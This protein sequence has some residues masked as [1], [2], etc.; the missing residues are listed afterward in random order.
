M[1]RLLLIL[2]FCI[3]NLFCYSQDFLYDSN[4]VYGTGVSDDEQTAEETAMLSLS[5]AL[6]TKVIN[7]T[8]RY[9]T[10]TD[11]GIKEGFSKNT[12][13]TSNITVEGAR[14][15]TTFEGG[16]YVVYYFFNKTEY[17]NTRTEAYAAHLSLVK[18]AETSSH[19]HSLNIMLG[20]LYRAYTC[21]DTELMA[22]LYPQAESMKK[23]ALEKMKK[24]YETGGPLT[25]HQLTWHSMEVQQDGSPWPK[26][27]PV[28]AFEY[29]HN[30]KWEYSSSRIKGYRENGSMLIEE[31]QSLENV[32][33]MY[34]PS[35]GCGIKHIQYRW[36]YEEMI[37]GEIVRINVPERFYFTEHVIQYI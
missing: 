8:E 14:K 12:H 23:H 33:I 6:C 26:F 16:K 18:A 19:P 24:I 13:L 22:V 20:N 36:L 2:V 10:E 25:A 3:A 11:A 17:I 5:R 30:G 4:Y 34:K 28:A 32:V 15:Y 31:D 29:I 1:R 35:A 37:D 9:V 21:M 27:F 7:E